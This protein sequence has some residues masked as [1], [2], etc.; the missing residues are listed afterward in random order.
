MRWQAPAD[1]AARRPYSAARNT[2]ASRRSRWRG[3]TSSHSS[4][5]QRPWPW[6][7][8]AGSSRRPAR[9]REAP[10]AASLAEALVVEFALVEVTRPAQLEPARHRLIKPAA[11]GSTA[12]RSGSPVSASR[13][14]RSQAGGGGA[15]ARRERRTRDPTRS[16]RPERR[17]RPAPRRA[18][19]RTHT[20]RWQHQRPAQSRGAMIAAACRAAAASRSDCW[21]CCAA[22][23]ATTQLP[24]PV[25]ACP[26][27]L[28][29]AIAAAGAHDRQRQHGGSAAAPSR[30]PAAPQRLQPA[31]PDHQPVG[32]GQPHRR[33]AVHAERA[34]RPD[35]RSRGCFVLRQP[36]TARSRWWQATPVGSAISRLSASDVSSTAARSG[37]RQPAALPI[38]HSIQPRWKRARLPPSTSSARSSALGRRLCPT[39]SWRWCPSRSAPRSRCAAG[40][41]CGQRSVS[42]ATRQASSSA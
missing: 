14:A 3:I 39:A 37:W 35:C 32:R 19:R 6:P 4:P 10:V 22:S 13:C 31:R 23:L 30:S 2:S 25:R 41:A 1:R 36:Q 8:G 42:S 9:R 7:H 27:R 16:C 20:A 11:E 28:P 17:L 12:R 24:R 21:P 40:R 33:V 34:W 15:A 5:P 26:R 38:S 18:G 29:S